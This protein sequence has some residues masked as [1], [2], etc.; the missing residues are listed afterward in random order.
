MAASFAIVSPATGAIV[1]THP[2]IDESEAL[3]RV[4]AAKTAS[5]EWRRTSIDERIRTVAAFVDAFV[6]DGEN[7]SRE[8]ASLIGRPVQHCRNEIKGFEERARHLLA[9]AKESLEDKPL[10]EKDN[11]NRFIRRN[12][13]GVVVII[14]AWNYPYLVSVNGVV[15]ALLGGNTVLLKQ[16][17]Q[18]FPCAD[19]FAIAFAK[20][21]LPAGVFQVLPVDHEV[22]AAVLRD[23]RVDHAHFTGSVR[24]GREVSKTVADKFMGLGLELGGKDPAY[25]RADADPKHAAENIIDGA[26]YNSGQSCCGVERVYVHAS[27]YDAFIRHAADTAAQY[28]LG[29]PFDENTNLGPVV[30]VAAA[31]AIRAQ[32]EEAVSKGATKLVGEAAFANVAKPG[33]AFVAPQVLINV[34]HSMKVMTE[35]TFGPIVGVMK[36]NS[37]EEAIQ[38]MNDSQYGLTASIW[39]KDADAAYK[40][41]NELEC[42]T[43]FLNRC[44]YLD[45]ALPWGGV[46]DSGRGVTLSSLGFDAVTRPKA[47]H[48]RLK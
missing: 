47:F 45:P 37:D 23:P 44:D 34:D 38:L 6:E 3:V 9:I 40:I 21:G 12:P 32:V 31:N 5:K 19:R 17:P 29:D 13:L 16:A 25:V 20:A 39:T 41:G 46:K 11:F 33:T 43:V 42:G 14:A 27:V 1:T 15:P 24:G 4:Q 26:M 2:L 35:E 48:F 36:V 28:N 18:T 10:P 8:L 30:N 7:I 22:A